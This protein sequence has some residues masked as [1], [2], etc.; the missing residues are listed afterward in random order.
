MNEEHETKEEKRKF[1]RRKDSNHEFQGYEP[2]GLPLSLGL[3]K[4]FLPSRR[5]APFALIWADISID[6]QTAVCWNSE[7][8]FQF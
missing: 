4:Q 3:V 6:Q 1:E 7:W 5:W 8:H 2:R